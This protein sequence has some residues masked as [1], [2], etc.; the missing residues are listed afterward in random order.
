MQAAAIHVLS[1][2]E[3]LASGCLDK[4]WAGE[5]EVALF[6]AIMLF[7]PACRTPSWPPL[8]GYP[9]H[10]N[11]GDALEAAAIKGDKAAWLHERMRWWDSARGLG[12]DAVA[13]DWLG[14]FP[15]SL[16]GLPRWRLP[17]QLMFHDR[18]AR[19]E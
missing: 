17:W 11:D 14:A 18:Y 9:V 15:S 10:S 5:E 7:R 13:N 2:G 4:R 12:S 8:P 19:P 16:Q 3:D 6:S 1:G